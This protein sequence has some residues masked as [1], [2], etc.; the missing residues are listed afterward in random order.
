MAGPEAESTAGPFPRSQTSGR[1]P[2][3]TRMKAKPLHRRTVGL[4]HVLDHCTCRILLRTSEETDQK[5]PSSSERAMACPVYPWPS[6]VKAK[7]DPSHFS[8]GVQLS[9]LSV[10]TV[11]SEKQ[12]ESGARCLGIQ[13]LRGMAV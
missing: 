8:T 3:C 11:I 6:I 9:S 10:A 12:S 2:R 5:C 4:P 1:G 13:F 7:P